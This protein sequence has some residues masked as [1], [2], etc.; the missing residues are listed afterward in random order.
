MDKFVVYIILILLVI[1]G[2]SFRLNGIVDNHS[3]WSDEAFISALARNLINGNITL[4]ETLSPIKYQPL[5]PLITALAF[6]IIGQNEFAAR[7]PS[8][9]FGSAGIIAAFLAA[10]KLSNK[11]GG[12]L[13]AFLFGFSQI[14]LAHST[15]VKP[16][17]ALETLI[18]FE[19]YFLLLLDS[20]YKKRVLVH[21]AVILCASLSSLFHLLGILAWIPYFIYLITKHW[22]IL[23]KNIKKPKVI[24]LTIFIG[25][26]FFFFFQVMEILKGILMVNNVYHIFSYNNLTFLR[27][28]LWKNYS[29]ITLPAVFGFIIMFFK[30]K[31]L[32]IGMGLWIVAQLFYWN[33]INTTHNVRYLIPLFGLLFVFFGIFWAKVGEK[34]VL[35]K[36]GFACTTA[37]LIIFL[38]GHKIIRKPV[39]YY[40]PNSDLYGDI[41]IADYKNTY[42]MIKKK[43]PNLKNI[44]VFN[45]WIDTQLWYLPEKSVTA[46]FMKGE[47]D[48]NPKRHPIDNAM[49]YG[50][51]KQFLTEK[52]KYPKGLLI[53]EDWESILP[54]DIKQYAKKNM[55]L[56]F[57]VEGLPQ[58]K[59]D[60]WPL[61]VYSWGME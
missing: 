56:E 15:Q 55:K 38:G 25:I 57:R 33:F 37:A 34:L 35:N 30:K 50:S 46:Y 5:Q 4:T 32:I 59:G 42:L 21:S 27:E 7:L 11:A 16:Y 3:F 12:L 20:S 26:F 48:K 8:I 61:E 10:S 13:A 39:F 41:Q 23:G 40:N 29:F 1:I 17:A 44:A 52:Q 14:N 49:V 45:D 2:F 24:V 47:F 22:H 6:K 36:S 51:V 28:L 9:I 43:Y 18:L 60:N 53:V 31:S 54:E 58:A 19:L